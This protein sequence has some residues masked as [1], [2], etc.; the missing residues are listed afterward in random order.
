[1]MQSELRDCSEIREALGESVFRFEGRRILIPGGNGFLGRVFIFFFQYLNAHVFR[2][3]VKIIAIDNY[4]VGVNP[5]AQSTANVTYLTHDLTTPLY[6]KLDRAPI[7][8]IINVSGMAS[9]SAYLRVPLEVLD[10]SY[11]GTRNVMEMAMA[12]GSRVLNFSSSE[13][14]GDPPASEIP[15]KETYMGK[16]SSTS[17]RAPYDCGKKVLEA[18]S[19]VFR[20]TYGVDVSIVL[21]FNVYGYMHRND[22][23]VMPNFVYNALE[24]KPLRVYS[25]GTQTR[26]FCFYSDFIVGALLVL[27]NGSEFSYNVGQ[28]EG[29]ITMVDLAHKVESVFE[30]TGLVEM[31]EPPPAYIEE[32]RRRC[33]DI[34]RVRAIG[35]EPR[36]PLNEGLNR[37]KTWLRSSE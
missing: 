15:T 36:V 23:R 14:Y 33:P 22:Y 19:H 4:I 24:N 26:T 37:I 27:L 11:I 5:V 20:E 25:P 3:P 13:C 1:M 12:K 30:R 32:P 21:P 9:P 18:V 6:L 8:F 17:K 28:Q 10:V 7:D 2:L 34:S 29:E 16:I 35:Y 31:V